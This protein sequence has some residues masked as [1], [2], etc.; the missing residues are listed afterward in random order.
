MKF[1]TI[2][3]FNEDGSIAATFSLNPEQ[4]AAVL[5]FGLSFAIA[6]GLAASIGIATEE[7]F[8]DDSIQ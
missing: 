7:D 2:P 6:S 1:T 5:E 8:D 3:T 4:A